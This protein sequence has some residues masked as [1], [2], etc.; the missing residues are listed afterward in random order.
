MKRKAQGFT[1]IEVMVAIALMAVVSIIAWRGLESIS[2]QRRLL[3]VDADDVD[4]LLRMLGQMERDVALRAP[5]DLLAP[6]QA[7][8]QDDDGA[9]SATPATVLPQSLRVVVGDGA[10]AP[11][12]VELIRA[13]P[14]DPS[15]WQRVVW[16]LD[17]GVLRRAAGPS[18][19][20]YPI[21]P[22][23]PG[24]PILAGVQRFAVRI[25]I[26]GQGWIGMPFPAT[27]V[28]ATGIELSVERGAAGGGAE[29]YSRVVVLQ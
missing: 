26:P 16:S 5:N 20:Q 22:A 27:G 25:W 9:A 8:G 3:T 7:D 23:G 28:A 6:D 21:P 15:A 12:A 18:S 17:G 13:D 2:N 29:R 11:P 1:L 19:R 4:A 24:A 10:A 14:A